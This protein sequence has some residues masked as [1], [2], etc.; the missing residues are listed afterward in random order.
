MV[1]KSIRILWKFILFAIVLGIISWISFYVWLSWRFESVVKNLDYH[2]FVTEIKKTP[3]LPDKLFKFYYTVHNYDENTTTTTQL[4]KAPFCILNDKV[5]LNCPCAEANYGFVLGTWDCLTVSLKLDSD[6]GPRKCLEYYLNNF[7]FC[8]GKV[9]IK[10][11]SEFYFK[12]PLDKLTQ[13][14]ILKL[15][16]MTKNPSMYNPIT[17]PERIEAELKRLKDT[18]NKK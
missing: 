6:V 12:K 15:C 10:N 7:D 17:Y 9:G 8:Y 1:K 2:S 5:N 11:A 13:D 14:E 16:L 18:T 3:E 4:M